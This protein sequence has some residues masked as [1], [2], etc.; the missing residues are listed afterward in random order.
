MKDL[1][2][3]YSGHSLSTFAA[4][5]LFA[6]CFTSCLSP[7]TVTYFQEDPN[8]PQIGRAMLEYQ[9]VIQKDDI[10][11]VVV[12]SLNEEANAIFNTRNQAMAA[13]MN[14]ATTGAVGARLQPIGYQVDFDGNIDVPMIGKV[15]VAGLSTEQAAAAVRTLLNRYLKEP[16]V[17]VRHVNFKIS[18]LG[19]VKAPST[20]MIPDEKFTLPQALSLAGDLTIY[21]T[22]TNVMIIRE[23]DGIRTFGRVDLTS[24]DLF[25]SPYYFLQR[26][27]VIYVEPT[28]ARVTSSDRTM[29]I[30]PI[31]LSGISVVAVILT[32]IF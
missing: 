26:N 3:W 32:R 13:H 1:T 4:F 21:G 16:T 11:S 18:V 15:K 6:A 28:K 2:R 31:V 19:E 30:L 8:S 12:G 22:R 27:D 5:L 25:D 7:K 24:R 10:L 9:P 23:V 17:V 29:Q 20:F 14:Y